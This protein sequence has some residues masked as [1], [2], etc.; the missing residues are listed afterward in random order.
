MRRFILWLLTHSIALAA[1]FALG[2][3][4]LPILTA[5][6]SPD[7]EMLAEQS[8]GAAFKA[9][10]T[11][12]LSGSDFLHWGEGEIALSDERIVH[13]GKLAPGPDYKLYLVQD[14]VEDEAGFL[15]LKA[16]A[17]QVGDVKS[18]NGFVVDLPEG[19][20]LTAYTTVL[21]WCESFGE[22]ITSAEYR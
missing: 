20:D 6:P 17:L 12:E 9:T 1:G 4:F 14:F 18:F 7:A 16:A 10:F 19:T 21:I 15:P 2:I 11:R 13:M 5:P 8:Q 3:Y 22:F